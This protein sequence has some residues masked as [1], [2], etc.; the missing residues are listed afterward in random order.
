MGESDGESVNWLIKVISEGQMGECGREGVD[1]LW[2]G[3]DE[4]RKEGKCRGGR[5]YEV[6]L[7][8]E[9]VAELEL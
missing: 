2:F 1:H 6:H 4:D 8:V 5:W 9:V 7:S 3:A